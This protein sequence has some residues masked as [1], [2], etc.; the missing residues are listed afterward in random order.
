[1]SLCPCHTSAMRVM[2]CSNHL[3]VND[4]DLTG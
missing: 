4:I 1:L 3:Q 2:V